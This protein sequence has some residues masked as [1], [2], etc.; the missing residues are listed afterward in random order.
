[1]KKR[2]TVLSICSVFAFSSFSFAGGGMHLNEDLHKEHEKEF[3][4]YA[5]DYFPTNVYFGDTHLHT[6]LS[7]DAGLGGARLPLKMPIVC[8]VA[9]R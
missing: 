9:S 8:P 6:W 5:E 1:M 7:V 3:S 4:P 2:I